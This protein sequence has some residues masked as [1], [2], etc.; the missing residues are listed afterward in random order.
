MD[1][2][3][4]TVK[5]LRAALD[6]MPDDL[7]VFFERVLPICGSIEEAGAAVK[8]QYGSFGQVHPCVIIRPLYSQI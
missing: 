5:S 3:Q 6:G 4:L 2:G 7:P 1:E 8:D